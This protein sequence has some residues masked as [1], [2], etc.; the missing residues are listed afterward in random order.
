MS[1]DPRLYIEGHDDVLSTRRGRVHRRGL[2]RE[3]VD[4]DWI[5]RDV[6]SVLLRRRA[7]AFTT[8]IANQRRASEAQM[9]TVRRDRRGRGCP[10]WARCSARACPVSAS[11][12]SNDLVERAD[13][14][15]HRK[16]GFEAS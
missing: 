5:D 4:A 7:V 14:R 1:L 8:V 6:S 13:A 16:L 9:T 3:V 2:Q 11:L 12:T 15:R 10:R